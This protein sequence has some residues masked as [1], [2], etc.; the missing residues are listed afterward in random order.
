MIRMVRL[1]NLVRKPAG[2]QQTRNPHALTEE[3]TDYRGLV[4]FVLAGRRVSVVRE[5]HNRALYGLTGSDIFA[6]KQSFSGVGTKRAVNAGNA[7]PA[8]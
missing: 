8:S 5:V 1:N 2:G 4:D 6:P 3:I 7:M